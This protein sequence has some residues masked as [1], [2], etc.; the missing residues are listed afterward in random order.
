VKPS[1]KYIVGIL[2]VGAIL[3]SSFKTNESEAGFAEQTYFNLNDY[4]SNPQK[5]NRMC[6]CQFGYDLKMNAFLAAYKIGQIADIHHL[7]HHSFSKPAHHEKNGQLYTCRAGFVDTSHLRA[8]SDWTV[9]LFANFLDFVKKGE[10]HD[11]HF[12]SDGAE[13][14][15]HFSNELLTLS[16]QDLLRLAQRIAY[17]RLMWHEVASW[18]YH[19]PVEMFSE[20]Q[21]AFSIE[22]SVSNFLG[23]V[24]AKK[25]IERLMSESTAISSKTPIEEPFEY[26][27]DQAL[28]ETLRELDV[29]GTKEKTKLA[30]DLVDRKYSQKLA[31]YKSKDVAWYDSS[32]YFSQIRYLFKRS[33]HTLET[34]HPWIVPQNEKN[35]LGC[36]L[37]LKPVT[38]EVPSMTQNQEKLT[39]FYEF[40]IEPHAELFKSSKRAKRHPHWKHSALPAQLTSEDLDS[41]IQNNIT[42]EMARALGKD[43][44]REP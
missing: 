33:T 42:P 36:N 2:L 11:L 31:P 14:N 26:A 32:I 35:I 10:V 16:M 13:L 40:K 22:D 6:L 25:A 34:I 20:Q 38:F 24:V 4:L 1:L 39:H 3:W 29:V 15:V 18:Y 8:G 5:K 27:M 19:P 43:F 12:P 30:F 23:T 21:S 44:D 7:G 28:E 41:I 17:H 37:N 9:H